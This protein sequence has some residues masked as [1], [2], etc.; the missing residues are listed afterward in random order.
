MGVGASVTFLHHVD[1]RSQHGSNICI[2]IIH[3]SIEKGTCSQ[4]SQLCG[5]CLAMCAAFHAQ[6]SDQ[7]SPERLMGEAPHSRNALHSLALTL[8]IRQLLLMSHRKVLPSLR[9]A[10]PPP[11]TRRRHLNRQEY[12]Y[13]VTARPE[14]V[15]LTSDPFLAFAGEAR[16]TTLPDRC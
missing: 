16:L 12:R 2:R 3:G 1:R 5:E 10:P 4:R 14:Q 15:S 9:L 13:P 8:L 11:I 6:W 7:L